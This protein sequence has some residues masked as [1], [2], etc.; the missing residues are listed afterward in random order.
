MTETVP[1]I[2][3]INETA[4]KVYL[5]IF[6]SEVISGYQFTESSMVWDTRA[7]EIAS[8]FLVRQDNEVAASFL[9]VVN[10]S[11]IEKLNE[12]A[13]RF[14]GV[15]NPILIPPVKFNNST[16]E[17]DKMAWKLACLSY[18]VSPEVLEFNALKATEVPSPIAKQPKES[19]E[20]PKES[21]EQPISLAL[22]AATDAEAD[23]EK[24]RERIL[25]LETRE[26]GYRRA[27]HKAQEAFLTLE[28]NSGYRSVD[29]NGK[30]STLPPNCVLRAVIATANALKSAPDS[31]TIE[32]AAM[33]KARLEALKWLEEKG[34]AVE[35]TWVV[36]EWLVEYDKKIWQCDP[37]RGGLA[38]LAARIKSFYHGRDGTLSMGGTKP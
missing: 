38:G 2:E 34:E 6:G 17:P 21:Q 23:L 5:A 10:W 12:L 37:K 8:R 15:W 11:T 31:E 4:K 3:Q 19:Q 1:S 33:N 14:Y 26:A 30:P 7:V 25:V 18:E 32:E 24:A 29:A 22:I 13:S 9:D 16:S 35:I 28:R 20:Q 36:N 27:L